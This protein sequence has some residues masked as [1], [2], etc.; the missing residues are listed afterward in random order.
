MRDWIKAEAPVIGLLKDCHPSGDNA[1]QGTDVDGATVIVR[2][3]KIPDCNYLVVQT[4][5][6]YQPKSGAWGSVAFG[7]VCLERRAQP[8]MADMGMKSAR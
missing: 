3:G 4:G 7:L 5:R 8:T 1:W 2:G 6:L